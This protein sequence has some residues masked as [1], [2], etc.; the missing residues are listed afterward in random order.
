M[1]INI[2]PL[3]FAMTSRRQFVSF[4]SLLL[5]R[6]IIFNNDATKA[7]KKLKPQNEH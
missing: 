5:F 3:V 2:F 1:Y 7:K 6:I 4:L